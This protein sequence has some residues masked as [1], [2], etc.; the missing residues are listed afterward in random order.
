ML[1]AFLSRTAQASGWDRINSSSSFVI[2]SPRSMAINIP[3]MVARTKHRLESL[4]CSRLVAAGAADRNAF[5][6]DQLAQFQREQRCLEGAKRT[7]R[8]PEHAHRSIADA[9]YH[10]SHVLDFAPEL[11]S[12]SIAAA[13]ATAAIH[14]VDREPPLE[15]RQDEPPGGR[16]VCHGSVDQQEWRPSAALPECD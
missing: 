12:S 11:V 3:S 9:I 8:V 7:V 2:P 14:R 13:T 15:L 1:G 16:V 10:R 6:Q 5:V 4:D